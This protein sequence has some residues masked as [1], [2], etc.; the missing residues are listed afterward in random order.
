VSGVSS[1]KHLKLL[2]LVT[3]FLPF[4]LPAP[5]IRLPVAFPKVVWIVTA[6]AAP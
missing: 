5:R 2:P 4:L 1:L 3:P 6:F